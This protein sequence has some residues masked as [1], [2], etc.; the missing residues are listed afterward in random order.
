VNGE[1][2]Q[3]SWAST[4]DFTERIIELLKVTRKIQAIKEFRTLTGFAL[5]ECKAAIDAFQRAYIWRRSDLIKINNC[6]GSVNN[7]WAVWT[8][9][10]D[11][12]TKPNV[13]IKG[14][15]SS[16]ANSISHILCDPISWT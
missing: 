3:Y 15:T 14:L 2:N 12:G 6:F 13:K 11:G 9:E 7:Y 5:R 10:C 16:A 4:A 8:F 1:G